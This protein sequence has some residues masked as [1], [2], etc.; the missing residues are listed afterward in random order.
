MLAG[1]AGP[2]RL[3]PVDVY[4]VAHHGSRTSSTPEWV[5]AIRPAAGVISLGRN[6]CYGHPHPNVL[7]TLER[8]QVHVLRTDWDGEIQFRLTAQGL[9]VRT[10]RDRIVP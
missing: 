8:A 10:K 2:D 9:K 4:K 1:A 3:P 7:A 5:E 6:N